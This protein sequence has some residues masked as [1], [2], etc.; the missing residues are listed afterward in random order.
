MGVPE[1]YTFICGMEQDI[2]KFF[3]LS[4]AAEVDF[5]GGFGGAAI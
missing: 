2:F 4:G 1:I 3:G 5:D